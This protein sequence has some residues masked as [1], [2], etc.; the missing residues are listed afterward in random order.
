MTITIECTA[1]ELKEFIQPQQEKL[2]ELT[3]AL[4][5]GRDEAM[6]AAAEGI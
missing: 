1:E 2:D 6:A 5:Q 4:S 3:K